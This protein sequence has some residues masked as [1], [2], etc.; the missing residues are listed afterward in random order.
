MEVFS[1]ILEDFLKQK[2]TG[3]QN[4]WFFFLKKSYSNFILYY[5]LAII[6]YK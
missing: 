3:K 6:N 4:Q 2:T 5:K 1:N